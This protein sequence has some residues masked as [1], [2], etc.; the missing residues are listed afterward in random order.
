VVRVAEALGMRV[1]AEGIEREEQAQFLADIGCESG[2]GFH[3]AKGQDAE[4]TAALV[5]GHRAVQ[6]IAS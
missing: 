1:V 5:R 3:F 2:Q 6:R 4:A